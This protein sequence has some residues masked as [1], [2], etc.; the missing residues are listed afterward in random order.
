VVQY[1]FQRVVGGKYVV[2]GNIGV[3]LTMVLGSSAF[4]TV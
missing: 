4:L 1:H 2:E 3:T